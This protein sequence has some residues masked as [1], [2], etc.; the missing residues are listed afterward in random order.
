MSR[1]IHNNTALYFAAANGNF[2]TV[3]FL[4]EEVKCPPDIAGAFNMTP[5]QIAIAANHSDIAHL[6]K[7]SVIPYIYTAIAMVKQL[8]LLK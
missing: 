1:T 5:L 4:I 6:Q 2:E 8:G 7:H 3:K